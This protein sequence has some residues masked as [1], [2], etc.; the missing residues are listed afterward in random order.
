MGSFSSGR[1]DLKTALLIPADSILF[2]FPVFFLNFDSYTFSLSA[3]S[4]RSIS[5]SDEIISIGIGRFS[6]YISVSSTFLFVIGTK[7]ARVLAEILNSGSLVEI[8]IVEF[9][10]LC[11]MIFE[12][13]WIVWM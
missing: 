13:F 5:G 9:V 2:S 3:G 1:R 7:F 10:G 4:A 12:L 11:M 8:V 6:R